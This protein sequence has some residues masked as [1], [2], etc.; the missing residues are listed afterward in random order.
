MLPNDSAALVKNN[1]TGIR[2][3]SRFM[4]KGLITAEFN[5]NLTDPMRSY[6]F[7]GNIGPMKMS[8]VNAA[9]IPLASMAIRSGTIKSLDFDFNANRN[10]STGKVTFLYNDLKVHLYKADT[11]KLKMNHLRIASLMANNLIIKHDNPDDSSTKPRVEKV[12]FV[13]PINYTFFKTVW[14][15]LLAG[16]KPSVGFDAATQVQVKA[17][18]AEYEQKKAARKLKKAMKNKLKP[19]GS[20]K[21]INF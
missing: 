21:L 11:L 2:V 10:K 19:P 13:R 6:N 8:A 12:N 17:Q 14:Q 3:S 15:S 16:L 5:F 9:A 18:M 4:N 20:S 7:K 1:M